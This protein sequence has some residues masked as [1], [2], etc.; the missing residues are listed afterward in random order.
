MCNIRSW[1]YFKGIGTKNA[2]FPCRRFPWR[3]SRGQLKYFTPANANKPRKKSRS[4]SPTLLF[5]HRFEREFHFF[6]RS[7]VHRILTFNT[8]NVEREGEVK[9]Q[10][11]RG[12]E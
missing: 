2:K 12:G 8:R 1:T 4:F 3:F 6:V 5:H 11:N 10:V 9:N 7:S